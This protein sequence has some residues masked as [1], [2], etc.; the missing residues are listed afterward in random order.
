MKRSFV[1]SGAPTISRKEGALACERVG[2][3]ADGLAPLAQLAHIPHTYAV[4]TAGCGHQPLLHRLNLHCHQV[5]DTQR[6]GNRET[7]VQRSIA[8]LD[9]W[10][11]SRIT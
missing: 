11:R 8:R 1:R 3:A 6:G 5:S 4:V 10:G 7:H 9:S 2:D